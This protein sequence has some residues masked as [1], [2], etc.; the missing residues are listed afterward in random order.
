M[1]YQFL[2]LSVDFS[3]ESTAGLSKQIG[4][5]DSSGGNQKQPK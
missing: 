1:I 2:S 4:Y 3:F 5:W